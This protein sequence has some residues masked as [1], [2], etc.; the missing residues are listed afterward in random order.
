MAKTSR[1]RRRRSGLI[2]VRA[3]GSVTLGTLSNLIVVAS[4]LNPDGPNDTMWAISADLLLSTD[5]MTAGEGPLLVGIAHSDYSVV[6][7]AEALAA[8]N[9]NQSDKIDVERGRRFVRDTGYFPV[10]ATHEV[11]GDGK[12]IRT[13][14]GFRVEAGQDLQLFVQNRSGVAL[15]TGGIVKFD[16]KMYLRRTV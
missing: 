9:F 4:G 16:G 7:I 13:K 6:E 11:I 10:I 15:T 2:V 3:Q 1:R 5:G 8:G 12:A 14:L